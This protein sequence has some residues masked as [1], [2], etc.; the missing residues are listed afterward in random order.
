MAR[1]VHRAWECAEGWKRREELRCD[2]KGFWDKY[3]SK[4]KQAAGISVE[5]WTVYFRDLLDEQ[6][7]DSDVVADTSLFVRIFKRVQGPGRGGSMFE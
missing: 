1:R 4:G 3:K 7:G 5:E 2:A 6:V